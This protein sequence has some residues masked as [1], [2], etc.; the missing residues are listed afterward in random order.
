MRFPR[1]RAWPEKRGVAFQLLRSKAGSAHLRLGH[2]SQSEP[3]KPHCQPALCVHGRLKALYE[4]PGNFGTCSHFQI[5]S[6]LS[7]HWKKNL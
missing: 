5:F 4:E 3:R 1:H 2:N 6:H 7:L